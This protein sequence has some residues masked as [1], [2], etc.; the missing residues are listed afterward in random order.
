M[1]AVLTRFK[2]KNGENLVNFIFQMSKCILLE[3]GTTYSKFTRIQFGEISKAILYIL[4]YYLLC[5]DIAFTT[6]NTLIVLISMYSTSLL[7]PF[8]L[9]FLLLSIL[10]Y[11]ILLLL[12]C[13]YFLCIIYCFYYVSYFTGIGLL[14][15]MY[16]IL[17]FLLCIYFIWI[18]YELLLLPFIHYVYYFLY[19]FTT[20]YTTYYIACTT[21]YTLML[22]LF[23]YKVY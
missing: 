4:Q 9:L 7:L 14:L 15:F 5:I 21:F 22:L 13:I 11:S 3:V 1:R 18:V 10:L 20:F 6:F 23:M 19:F 16:S 17:M 8:I 12:L 2:G